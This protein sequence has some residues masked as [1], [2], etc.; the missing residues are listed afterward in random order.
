MLSNE[1][2]EEDADDL[3]PTQS[4]HQYEGVTFPGPPAFLLFLWVKDPNTCFLFGSFAVIYY[5]TSSIQPSLPL[6]ASPPILG[7][8][9][10]LAI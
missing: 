1:E 4:C 5:F 6:A 10:R 7:R 8:A 2:E 3:A 9:T